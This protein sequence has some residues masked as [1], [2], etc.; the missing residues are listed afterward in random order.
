MRFGSAVQWR[1]ARYCQT[2]RVAVGRGIGPLRHSDGAGGTRLAV[3][4]DGLVQDFGRDSCI[5]RARYDV[6]RPPGVQS[7]TS[8]ISLIGE[9]PGSGLRLQA[10]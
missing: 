10:F 3:D 2:R 7:T 1:W 5:V 9:G 4:D 8:G 6:G